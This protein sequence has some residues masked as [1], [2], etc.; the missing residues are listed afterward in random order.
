MAAEKNSELICRHDMPFG[1]EIHED[2]VR[3]RLWAPDVEEVALC[4]AAAEGERQVVMERRE[5]GWHHHTDR[6][7]GPGTRYSFKIDGSLK[8]PDP[9]SRWQPDGVHGASMV[10]DPLAWRWQDK[11]WRGR[12]LSEAVFYELH[13][14]T[15]CSAGKYHGVKERLNYLADLGVTAIELM[16]LAAFAGSRNW[17]YDGVLPFAPAA[18]YGTPGQLKSLVETAHQS[19]LMVFLDVVYNHFGPEGNYLHLYASPFFTRRYKTPWGEAINLDKTSG[20]WV[21]RFF[22]ENA[23]YWLEEFRF[24]GLRL[25]AV[26]SLFDD[27][28]PTFLEEL[29]AAVKQGPGRDR[30]VHLV[31]ENYNNDAGLLERER[32][33][34]P[35]YYS[36]Q[37]NDDIHHAM[38]VLLTG[39]TDGYYLDYADDP[40]AH[41]NRCLLEGFAYQGEI[42]IWRGKKRGTPS[43][44]LPPE[45]FIGFLQ[46]H[47]QTGNRAFGERLTVL[48]AEEKLAVM[49]AV[50]LLAPQPPLL[51]MG[52]EWGSRQPF[53]YFCD[54]GE[55]LASQVR[56]GRKR[57]FGGF[58][59]FKKEEKL[60]N[61][62]DPCA[63]ETFEKCVLDWSLQQEKSH[64]QWLELHRKLLRLRRNFIMPRLGQGPITC[65]CDE[66]AEKVV[67]LE[68]QF[69]DATR[70][71]LI[72]NFSSRKTSMLLPAGQPLYHSRGAGTAGQMLNLKPWSASFLLLADGENSLNR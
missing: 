53:L 15:F 4:L 21:R 64:G 56:E 49:T 22:I 41:L 44:A 2:G 13:V 31:L 36:A 10:A 48:A 69:G 20:Y 57:E 1:A 58:A 51:F 34:K 18:C 60:Q 17:G 16:P 28:Q 7:S 14:G 52:Q 39:E 61:I 50:L 27:S 67:K 32:D 47:D 19:G 70:L 6:D 68:W 59:A 37:W 46:N 33:G 42:S 12:P 30:Q 26:H 29:A 45:A 54:F 40:L 5:E 3:F 63:P 8:V 43:R 55:D 9:A 24:D 35:R 38:H 72:A 65:R 66:L 62:P 71:F 25:D 11:D 23:L